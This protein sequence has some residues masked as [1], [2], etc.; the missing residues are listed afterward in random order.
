MNQ[1]QML[2]CPRRRSSH[3]PL[4]CA[5]GGS[6]GVPPLRH[7]PP[8]S[9][10]GRDQANDVRGLQIVEALQDH[11]NIA[12]GK[13][14]GGGPSSQPGEAQHGDHSLE[15]LHSHGCC[16]AGIS[17][18]SQLAVKLGVVDDE[19]EPAAREAAPPRGAVPD[20]GGEPRGPNGQLSW[21]QN[22][23]QAQT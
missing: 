11:Q 5:S 2:K 9:I 17:I 10:R 22:Q 23:N 16:F 20:G 13:N 14:L 12:L 4:G 15:V 3:L 21:N 19:E 7:I 8:T 6:T 18:R 1:L